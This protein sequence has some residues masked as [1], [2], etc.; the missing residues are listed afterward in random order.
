MKRSI[1]LVSL[2]LLLCLGSFTANAQTIVDMPPPP[3]LP[4]LRPD[5][6]PL[7]FRLPYQFREGTGYPGDFQH[8]QTRKPLNGFSLLLGMRTPR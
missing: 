7:S 4:V 6:S 1:G 5:P 8:D 3:P 2:F